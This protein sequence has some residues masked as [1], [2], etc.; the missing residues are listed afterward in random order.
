MPPAQNHHSHQEEEKLRAF[1]ADFNLSNMEIAIYFCLEREGEQKASDLSLKLNMH[2]MQT[3]RI[4]EK[5]ISLGFAKKT[6]E[7]PNR[8]GA[9]PLDV[10]LSESLQNKRREY[11]NLKKEKNK[12][13]SLW[14]SKKNQTKKDFQ[15]PEFMIIRLEESYKIILRMLK[16]AKK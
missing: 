16:N 4:L 5:L 13:L 3:Y 10:V 14:E 8:F 12:L 11:D 6:F 9:V 7:K 1:F 2:K 15:T